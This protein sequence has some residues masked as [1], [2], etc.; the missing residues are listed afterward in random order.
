[1]RNIQLLNIG[2]PFERLRQDSSECV[3]GDVQDRHV[4]K[5]ANLG[6][7]AS[8]EVIVQE[9]NLVQCAGHFSNAAW[10]AALEIVIGNHHNRSRGVSESVRNGGCEPV[11]VQEQSIEVLVEELRRQLTLKII[12]PKIKVF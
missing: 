3:G 4:S 11:I 12:E 6:G 10:N 9:N 2:K 5:Q 7:Q 8:G 1:V